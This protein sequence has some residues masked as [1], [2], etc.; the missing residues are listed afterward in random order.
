MD[1][2]NRCVDAGTLAKVAE[3]AS[4]GATGRAERLAALE[5]RQADAERFGAANLKRVFDAGISVA[6]GTDAGN[7][8]TLHGP[9]VYAEMEAMQAAGLSALQVLAV[10]T[11]GG[12]RA[13]RGEKSFGTVEAGKDADL[14]L[15]AADPSADIRAMRKVRWVVRGG[16]PRSVEELS[17]VV[18]AGK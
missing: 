11:L 17:A 7:P 16:V 18:A 8:L 5:K 12:A 1:D 14:L 4:G 3:S 9:S 10:S 13:M 2:P 6:M 15:V